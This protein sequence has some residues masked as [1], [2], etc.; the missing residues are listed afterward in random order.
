MAYDPAKITPEQ[1]VAAI[2]EPTVYRATLPQLG[3]ETVAQP[4][5]GTSLIVLLAL[6]LDEGV[7]LLTAVWYRRRSRLSPPLTE[8]TLEEM[9]HD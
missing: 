2:N 8:D 1:I 3:N 9:P 7:S 5:G 4:S 6:V